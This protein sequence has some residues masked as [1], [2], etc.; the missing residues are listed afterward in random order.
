MVADRRYGDVPAAAGPSAAERARSIAQ[1]G[2]AA[3]VLP[4]STGDRLVPLLHQVSADGDPLVVFGED[5]PLVAATRTASR[6]ELPAM[7]ELTDTAPVPLRQPVRG[8]LWITG[9]LC[10]LDRAGARAAAVTIS[11][12]CP[13]PRLLDVG[14][15]VTVLRLRAASLVVA[16]GE[17][18]EPV[19]PD[20]FARAEPDPFCSSERV[21]LRHLED[22]H[23]DV[24]DTLLTHV[25]ASL[26]TPAARVRPLGLDRFGL[27]LRVEIDNADRDVRLRF[28]RP[29]TDA[30]DLGQQFRQLLG[31]PFVRY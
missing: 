27:R 7:V 8:L 24:L 10:P 16:D 28:S 30:R 26:R 9:W 12:R 31:C 29:V 18:A 22:G 20:E 13:D 1:R 21:W 3:A 2:A 25:P 17:G 19:Q 14:R 4:G 23:S 5:H 6:R 15:G 11:E